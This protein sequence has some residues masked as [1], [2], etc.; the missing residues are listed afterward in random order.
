MNQSLLDTIAAEVRDFMKTVSEL[1]YIC[2]V[3]VTTSRV[4]Y[5]TVLHML[6]DKLGISHDQLSSQK[7]QIKAIIKVFLS[8]SYKTQDETIKEFR[9]RIEK[10]SKQDMASEF[11]PTED[12]SGL[13][14]RP[15]VDF[16]ALN[17]RWNLEN[18]SN[19]TM[20]MPPST[21]RGILSFNHR[22]QVYIEDVFDHRYYATRSGKNHR[23]QLA[24]IANRRQTAISQAK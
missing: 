13:I 4:K 3:G 9:E 22:I 15:V 7:D 23:N 10:N 1:E 12:Y 18:V 20:L 2:I 24:S 16:G 11:Y 5:K 8:L 17:S 6:E 21:M 14:D 19:G